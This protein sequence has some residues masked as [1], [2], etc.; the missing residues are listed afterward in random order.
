M[1]KIL[2]TLSI[3]LAMVACG[4]TNNLKAQLKETKVYKCNPDILSI[5]VQQDWNDDR[6]STQSTPEMLEICPTTHSTCCDLKTMEA[7]KNMFLLEKTRF[8]QWKDLHESLYKTFKH[9]KIVLTRVKDHSNYANL[10]TC[11]SPEENA[12]ITEMIT[13]VDYSE[14][15]MRKHLRD[16][17]NNFLKYYS[18]LACEFCDGRATESIYAYQ[19]NW[20]IVHNT[21]NVYTILH[22]MLG[23]YSYYEFVKN[24]SFLG[25][26]AQCLNDDDSS[27][28]KNLDDTMVEEKIGILHDCLKLGPEA[29]VKTKNCIDFTEHNDLNTFTALGG[30]Y[31]F[32]NF[33]KKDL[34]NLKGGIDIKEPDFDDSITDSVFY[35]PM[36][37]LEPSFKYPSTTYDVTAGLKISENSMSISIWKNANIFSALVATVL[38]LVLIR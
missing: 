30:F 24:T 10:S 6:E 25:K 14:Y 12:K 37:N 3:A 36:D 38:S 26:V 35:T 32:M 18:G 2:F 21:N 13:K 29:I 4:K 23:L 11:L 19:N 8:I 22:N 20:H 31:D 1:Q 9:K 15:E 17:T 33:T 27:H 28:Y 34:E 16:I 7:F 5:F